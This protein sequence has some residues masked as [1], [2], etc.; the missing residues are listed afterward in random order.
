MEIPWEKYQLLF[1]VPFLFAA[2]T[3]FDKADY[4]Y[5]MQINEKL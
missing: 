4:H 1:I 5:I 3:I 2:V